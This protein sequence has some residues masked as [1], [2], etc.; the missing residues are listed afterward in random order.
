MGGSERREENKKEKE[1][2]RIHSFSNKVS[3][4]CHDLST[5]SWYKAY[6]VNLK[7]NEQKFCENNMTLE[8][9]VKNGMNWYILEV[10]FNKT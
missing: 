8:C 9:C 5:K 10:M 3:N 6:D 4:A 2:K 1:C 7:R